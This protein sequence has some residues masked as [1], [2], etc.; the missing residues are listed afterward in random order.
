M[1]V[2]NEVTSLT[3]VAII[4]LSVL[5]S[6]LPLVFAD[7]TVPW[8]S[9]PPDLPGDVNADAKV[10]MMDIGIVAKAYGSV[11][12]GSNWNPIADVNDDG[13]VNMIDIGMVSKYYGKT[14]STSATPIA[15]STSFEFSVPNDGDE[16]VWYYI[17]VRFY[18]SAALSNKTFNLVAGKS[19]D[20][21]IRKV[22]VDNILVYASQTSGLFNI[23]L[24]QPLEGYHM[25]E[26]E[27]LES[28]GAGLINFAVKTT[29]NEYAWL[30]RFRVYVPNYSDKE[31]RYTVKTHSNFTISDRYFIKGFADDY[32]DDIKLGGGWLYQDWQ[33]SSYWTSI[34][35]WATDSMCHADILTQLLGEMLS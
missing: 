23:A 35:A 31:Y 8:A 4:L 3:L 7:Y 21:A 13:K 1:R 30:D 22:K 5:F 29:N 10:D 17:L 33:W 26:L 24:G 27:Y 6:S 9:F 14:Y 2:K 11:F 28:T 20:D 18:V 12:G 16:A 32:I 19:V 34:Y 15:Y 25:L